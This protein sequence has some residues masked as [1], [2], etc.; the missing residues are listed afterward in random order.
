MPKPICC[1]RLCMGCAAVVQLWRLP[2]VGYLVVGK[3]S[4]VCLRVSF[5]RSGCLDD[6]F[7]R[8]S[9]SLL[10]ELSPSLEEVVESNDH[11]PPCS[12][13]PGPCS[14]PQATTTQESWLCAATCFHQP[15][16]ETISETLG[17]LQTL[18]PK[19]PDYKPK[20]ES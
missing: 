17:K 4:S 18:K 16:K 13:V 6:G 1:M 10:Q 15:N 11:R 14:G 7:D 2:N 20:P 12:K 3:R 19:A 8:T 9:H 5:V